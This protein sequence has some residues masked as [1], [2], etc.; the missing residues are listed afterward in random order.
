[1]ATTTPKR[2]REGRTV[3]A[4]AMEHVANARR[5]K[6]PAQPAPVARLSLPKLERTQ[7]RRS[8]ATVGRFDDAPASEASKSPDPGRPLVSAK[9]VIEHGIRVAQEVIDQQI[10]SGERILRHLRKASIP[11]RRASPLD[12]QNTASLTERTA[13][14]YREFG[15]LTLELLET[16]AET[17]TVARVLAK[18]LGIASASQSSG[19][20]PSAGESPAR[21]GSPQ[22]E[23]Q[24]SSRKPVK[25][26]VNWIPGAVLD[27]VQVSGLHNTGCGAD[28][29]H[30]VPAELR[31]RSH[32]LSRTSSRRNLFRR[33]RGSR[34]RARAGHGDRDRL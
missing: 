8:L 5:G 22:C 33:D 34:H 12:D 26:D 23:V 28:N 6:A 16:L 10:G 21:P 13:V 31:R 17:P 29:A 1:M 14:L 25:V 18:W 15:V 30:R 9:D 7:P 20:S 32:R 11:K 19:G 3:A 24:I 27:E 4:R 2:P